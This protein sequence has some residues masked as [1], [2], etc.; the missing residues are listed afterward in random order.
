[1]TTPV[2]TLELDHLVESVRT[3]MTAGNWPDAIL[4]VREE[5]DRLGVDRNDLVRQVAARAIELRVVEPL[6]MEPEPVQ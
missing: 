2:L 6:R 4:K 3:L 5:A 1:M